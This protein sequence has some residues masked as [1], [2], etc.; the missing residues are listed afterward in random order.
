M[1]T[2]VRCSNLTLKHCKI[3][4]KIF[5]SVTISLSLSL[6]LNLT[7]TFEKKSDYRIVTLHFRKR[8]PLDYGEFPR[9]SKENAY[10]VAND[11]IDIATID[12]VI[13]FCPRKNSKQASARCITQLA[14]A[15]IATVLYTYPWQPFKHC[16]H[17][18]S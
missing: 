16:S 4:C 13:N 6:T 14:L 17:C 7:L 10:T 12:W 15:T 3:S 1:E 11:M 8:K 18:L 9:S 5:Y 2:V